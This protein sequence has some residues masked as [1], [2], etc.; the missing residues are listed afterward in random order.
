MYFYAHFYRWLRLVAIRQNSCII[1][2]RYLTVSEKRYLLATIPI[3]FFTIYRAVWFAMFSATSNNVNFWEVQTE[4]GLIFDLSAQYLVMAFV[5]SKLTQT[6]LFHS[7]NAAICETSFDWSR[8][9]RPCG[10]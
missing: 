9:P 4:T 7:C 6:I 10:D 2:F 1:Q 5:S 8:Y 3:F